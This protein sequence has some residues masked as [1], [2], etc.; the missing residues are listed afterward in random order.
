MKPYITNFNIRILEKSE[1]D[2]LF[3][4]EGKPIYDIM[5]DLSLFSINEL[6]VCADPFLFVNDGKLYLFYEKQYKL[7]GKGYICMVYTS[8]L[9]NW[10]EEKVVLKEPFHLSF[11]FVFSDNGRIYMVP[12]SSNDFSI[13]L[14]EA[15]DSSLCN[16]KYVKDLTSI[17]DNW[18]DSS[19]FV[20]DNVYYLFTTTTD[21]GVQSQ[22]LLFT[23]DLNKEFIEHPCSPI[24]VGNDCGR[25]AGCI[26][27]I[28]GFLYRPAQDCIE[29]YGV[30]VNILMIDTLSPVMYKEHLHKHRIVNRDIH[31]YKG[32][33]HQFS[34]VNFNNKI[35]VATDAK[36][37]NYNLIETFRRLVSHF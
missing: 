2:D 6:E 10:S 13:R 21:N 17:R 35:I 22:K 25:N 1:T 3:S 30:Q 16:W 37:K 31:F 4:Y 7:S 18:V 34:C 9:V 8:D 28:G 36:V 26:I 29:G 23:D 5:S 11:P 33:G 14:Y 27:D 32:G 15:V 19:I 20:N 24:Y 12:E